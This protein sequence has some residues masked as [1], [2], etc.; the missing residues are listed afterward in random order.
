MLTVLTIAGVQSANLMNDCCNVR[1]VLRI[2]KKFTMHFYENNEH[3]KRCSF[4]CV[5]DSAN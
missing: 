1:N 5:S 4:K 3:C 2:T